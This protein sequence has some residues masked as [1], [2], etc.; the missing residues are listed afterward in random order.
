V[1][2]DI[3]GLGAVA[4]LAKGVIDK[5]FPDK[6][7]AERQQMVMAMTVI[8]GQLD[9]NKVEAGNNNLFVSGW[10]PYVGWVCGSGFAIQFVIGPLAEWGASLAG[11]PLKFPPLDLETMLPLLLGMLGLGGLRTIE[12]KAGV[13]K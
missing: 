2:F 1:G 11:H 4:D 3:T 6:S 5:F 9:V 12:K 13:A 10:R 7:E 8:Q